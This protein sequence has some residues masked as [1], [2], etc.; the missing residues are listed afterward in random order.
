[1]LATVIWPLLSIVN[2][3][4]LP[5][6]ILNPVGLPVVAIG[7]P[8]VAVLIIFSAM[9]LVWLSTI[10]IL[11]SLAL[12]I[13][14]VIIAVLLLKPAL[15]IWIINIYWLKASKS[16]WSVSLTVIWP[17]LSIANALLILPAV[18]LNVS[19]LPVVAIG[20]PT[21][22]PLF[23]FSITSLVWLLIVIS[24]S[25]TSVILTTIVA[26]LS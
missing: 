20:I 17:L 4:L 15:V 2:A 10:A 13:L 23:A 11:F 16:I 12:L 19:G 8:T 14:I 5:A 22:S 7:W 25:G 1:M 26:V 3:L 9:L 18:I 24:L 21:L 6:V